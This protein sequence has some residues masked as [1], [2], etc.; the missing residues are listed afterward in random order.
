MKTVPSLILLS[1][2]SVGGIS[3]EVDKDA[4]GKLTAKIGKIF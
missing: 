4:L 3:A 2:L 1:M